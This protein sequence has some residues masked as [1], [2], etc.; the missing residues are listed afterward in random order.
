MRARVPSSSANLGAGFDTLGLAL[1]R[2]TDVSI[3]PSDRLGGSTTGEG[4]QFPIDEHHLAVRIVRD[5]L[6]HDRVTITIASDIPVS[7]GLGSSAALTVAVAAACGHSDPL[8]YAA[9]LEGHADNAAAAVLGGFV[10]ATISDGRVWARRLPLDP[11]LLFVA[12]IPDRHLNTSE[13]REVLPSHVPVADAVANL[14]AMGLMVAGLADHR[15][16]LAHAAD[17]RLHQP[18]RTALFPESTGL[19]KAMIGAG[20]LAAFWSGA[21]PTLLGVCHRSIAHEVRDAA[22]ESLAAFSVAG[23]AEIVEADTVGLVVSD[24]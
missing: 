16:L 11:E 5:I 18:Y 2:S 9:M 10:T 3:E 6:G 22:T 1:S 13:A 23:S 24:C 14:G 12:V 7:R 17:D 15:A 21:G 8:S 4:S 19:L 20:A